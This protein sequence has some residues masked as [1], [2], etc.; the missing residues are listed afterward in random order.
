MPAFTITY[1]SLPVL[2]LVIALT[3]VLAGALCTSLIV[4]D[5]MSHITKVAAVEATVA[6]LEYN[7][8]LPSNHIINS[9][10]DVIMAI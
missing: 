10:L 9:S 4:I 6:I 3:V 2:S 8:S 1:R 5:M 7:P